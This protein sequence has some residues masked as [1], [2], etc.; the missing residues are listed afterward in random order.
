M[1]TQVGILA[2]DYYRRMDFGKGL[3]ALDYGDY[4]NLT[5]PIT[6]SH[7]AY[8]GEYFEAKGKMVRDTFSE[9]YV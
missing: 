1:L 5:K 3:G 8:S 4:F 6:G 7:K 2:L 9:H